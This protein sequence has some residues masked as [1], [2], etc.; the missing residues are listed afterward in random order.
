MIGGDVTYICK[1]ANTFEFTITLYQDC[2]YGEPGA[3][4]Q[5]NPAYYSIFDAGTN[6]YVT[7]D[8]VVAL[9][10]VIVDPN[11]SNACINNYPNTCMRKQT[12]RFSRTLQP[13]NNG[14]VIV[15]ERCCRNASISNIV[16]P[17]NVGV[18]YF[19]TIPP[20][21]NGQCPNNSAVFKN[22]PPQIIC[23][24]N[25]FVYDF[26]AIDNDG[27]SLSY[28]LCAA[29]PG[30]STSDAK[31]YGPDM[32][33]PVQASVVYKAPR[34]AEVPVPGTPPMQINPVTGLLTG[35]PSSTGRFV[36]SVC[37]TEWRNG[38]AIN[39]ISR[40]VQF[41]ITNCSKAVVANIP[42]LDDEPNT[43]AIEC[44]SFTVNFRNTSTGGFSYH[45][46][47]GVAG[48]TSTDFEPTF[49]YPDTGTYVVSLVVNQGSTCPD[50]IS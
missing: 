10:T 2:L 17:G 33:M 42:E 21:Q 24:N 32:N 13:N 18:T 41:V 3:L 27:D 39:T 37:V 48:A 28:K 15:Y 40:D 26:S 29:R 45:W 34:T 9:S 50:S 43:Y 12:F 7:G 25:P 19:A 4:A 6:A 11:F 5:D 46:N 35:T 14:Y 16:S 30:G 44:K 31:P 23:A 8:S 36:V 22:F 49:T 38:V 20:F 47:F 1:G